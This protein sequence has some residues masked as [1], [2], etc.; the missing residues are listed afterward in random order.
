MYERQ[1]RPEGFEWIEW[2][3][4]ENSVLSYLRKGYE[5]ENSV[6]VICNFTP[7]PRENYKVGVPKTLTKAGAKLKELFNSNEK[8]YGGSGDFISKKVKVEAEAWNGREHS[9]T[10]DLAPLA[11]MVFSLK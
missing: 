5:A 3:D 10:L 9:I 11:V 6:L 7:V 8:K 2:S 1:F 4:S